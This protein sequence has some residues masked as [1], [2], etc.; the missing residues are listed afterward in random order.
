[1]EHWF[2]TGANK[3]EYGNNKDRSHAIKLYKIIALINEH[4]RRHVSKK[5]S[6][7]NS[8][9]SCMSRSAIL[10]AVVSKLLSA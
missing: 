10:L 4:D 2:Y 6:Y 1:M 9:I 3:D 5:N 7:I 8:L